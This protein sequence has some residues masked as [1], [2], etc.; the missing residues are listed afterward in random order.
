MLFLSL[1]HSPMKAFEIP[2]YVN[3]FYPNARGEPLPEAGAQRTL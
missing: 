2:L 1:N 3:N